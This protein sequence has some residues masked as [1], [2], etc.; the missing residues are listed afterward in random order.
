MKSEP[1]PTE[2][3]SDRAEN[4][5]RFRPGYPPAILECLRAEAGLTA[6]A[7]I[8]DVGS[9][10]G[11]LTELF[12][13]DGHTVY[14]VEPNDAM[15]SAAESRLSENPN[16]ISVPGRAEMTTLVDQS[17]DYIT[18]GQAF[19]WFDVG[20]ARI[21]FLRILRPAGFVVLVWNARKYRDDPFMAAYERILGDFGMGY[22]VVTH[23]SHRGDMETLF[24]HGWQVRV[25]THERHLDFA[26]LWG[27]FLSA[28]YAPQ[29]GDQHYESIRDALRDEFDRYQ[30]EGVVR[31]LYDTNLFFGHLHIQ[32]R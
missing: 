10:T 3:F 25:F 31:F 17:V 26:T 6:D 5:A 14:A 27:G 24:Q 32:S 22:H 21:E 15:R 12:L 1:D 7:V 20:L 18:A 2:R 29:P 4:Y 13:R 23:R 8:A 30:R 19:H 28:S 16:F 9:G 11:I